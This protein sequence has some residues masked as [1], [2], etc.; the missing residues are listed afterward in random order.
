MTQ[1]DLF[2]YPSTPGF[3]RTDTSRDAAADIAA[4]APTLR[5][6]VVAILKCSRCTADEVAAVMNKSV[7]TIRPRVAELAV[8]GLIRDTDIRRQNSS[9]KK[10]IVWEAT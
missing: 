8:M 1:P 10:A 4:R 2:T 9:G 5:E 7:L 3:M 6:R